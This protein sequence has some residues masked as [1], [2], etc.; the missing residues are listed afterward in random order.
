[1]R[2]LF[3][4]YVNGAIIM[5]ENAEEHSDMIHM[6]LL[7]I[8]SIEQAIQAGWYRWRIRNGVMFLQV[9]E[10]DIQRI[11]RAARRINEFVCPDT[12]LKMIVE[13]NGKIVKEVFLV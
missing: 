10:V 9:N 8:D 5:D 1:M 3:G 4:F 7:G 6:D 13:A 2:D 12:E 11:D